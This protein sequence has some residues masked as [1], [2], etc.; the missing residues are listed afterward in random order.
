V[1]DKKVPSVTTIL[2]KT[3]SEDKKKAL[4]AWRERIGYQQAQL[5][6]QEAALRGTEMHYVLENYINGIGY[7]NLSPKG[8]L[9]RLMAHKIIDNLEPLKIV[10]GNEINLQYE[11]RWAGSTDLVGNFDGKDTIIDF[12]QANK[13][14]K[15][16]WIEDYFYQIAAYSLA[17]KKN[18]GSIEQGLICIC[19][20]DKQYQQFKMDKEKLKEYEDKWFDRVEKFYT[21][22]GN[23]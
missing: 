11:G 1:G 7:L 17:H 16:D 4:D 2:A 18:Y 10:Y 22:S 5:V 14:K 12:K 19:T 13:L 21:M 8:A 9:S 15:E 23:E 3:A 6:T 20:Q